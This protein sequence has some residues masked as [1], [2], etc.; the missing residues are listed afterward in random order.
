VIGVDVDIEEAARII[1]VFKQTYPELA[2]WQAEQSRASR[3]EGYAQTI[4][5]R[6]WWWSWRSHDYDEV[7]DDMEDYQV[8][9]Y[10]EGFE[11]NLSLNLPV[12]G[13]AAEVMVVALAY[14][15]EA[16]RGTGASLIATVHDE[17]V[18][19]V[20]S[21]RETVRRV[22]RLIMQKMTRA[23]LEFNPD[24]PWR[25]IV[26]V[27]LGKTWGTPLSEDELRQIHKWL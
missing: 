1:D 3:Q 13:S 12:Q 11:R 2:A 10:L 5:G 17:F 7:P 22:R 14:I 6:R 20:P 27:T 4:G 23:W 19:M 18:L 9:A 24:A 26:V 25:G 16:L 21:D 15:D 8:D